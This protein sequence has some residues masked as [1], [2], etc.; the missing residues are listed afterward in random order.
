MI[1]PWA[2]HV[3]VDA[4]AHDVVTHV[5]LVNPLVVRGL[6]QRVAHS[7]GE[8]ETLGEGNVLHT[9][10]CGVQGVPHQG[11]QGSG[12]EDNAADRGRAESHQGQH[13]DAGGQHLDHHH[14][15][16]IVL[17]GGATILAVYQHLGGLRFQPLGICL[18]GHVVQGLCV[19]LNVPAAVSPGRLSF[20]GHFAVQR[21][22]PRRLIELGVL[23]PAVCDVL[24]EGDQRVHGGRCK[25]PAGRDDAQGLS[26]GHGHDFGGAAA[27]G[28]CAHPAGAS[29]PGGHW[30]AHQSLAHRRRR[31][32]GHFIRGNRPGGDVAL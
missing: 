19:V 3:V 6:A 29:G 21:L 8:V 20:A 9:V 16:H 15:C 10:H 23:V 1:E 17:K 32:E 7:E 26:A 12:G 11:V 28:N 18:E 30:D 24:V 25:N 2:A 5:V 4:A 14:A 13:G 31:S 22:H 27:H